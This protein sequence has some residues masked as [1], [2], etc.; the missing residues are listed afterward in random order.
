MMSSE[1]ASMF[2][3]QWGLTHF[4]I[5]VMSTQSLKQLSRY[6]LLTGLLL[7][8]SSALGYSHKDSYFVNNVAVEATDQKPFVANPRWQ[9]AQTSISKSEAAFAAKQR[10]GGKI[11][12][13]NKSDNVYRVKLLLDS[14]KV[15]IVVVDANT[16]KVLGR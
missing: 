1:L 5:N 12:S 7:S 6:T 13:V 14:G 8:T 3:I 11:L 2:G 4:N 10:Y 16:G 15:I 9:L